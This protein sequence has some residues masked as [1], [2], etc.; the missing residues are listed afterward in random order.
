MRKIGLFLGSFDPIHIGHYA[1]IIK[2]LDKTRTD[3]V[4]QVIIVPAFQNPW[5]KKK[6]TAFNHR[7]E[8][9]R[10]IAHQIC[11]HLGKDK[12]IVSNI[13]ERLKATT[14][15]SYLTLQE[16]Q[17]QYPKDELSIICGTDIS[18][19]IKDWKEGDWILKNFKLLVLDRG[20]QTEN[21]ESTVTISS[22][23]IRN[24]IANNQCPLPFIS[25]VTYF[26]IKKNHLYNCKLKW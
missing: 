4:D 8:M 7:F 5:K 24:M 14:R 10:T 25:T 13:E 26:Y 12:V 17:K 3:H 23:V 22:T 18:N 2:S 20:G 19:E 21:Q 9:C 15:Y 6:A 11:R 16:L 1:N